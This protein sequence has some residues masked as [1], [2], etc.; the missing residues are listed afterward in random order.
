MNTLGSV[1]PDEG[2]LRIPFPGGMLKIAQDQHTNNQD[3]RIARFR[4]LLCPILGDLN[5]RNNHIVLSVEHPLIGDDDLVDVLG[6]Q[7]GP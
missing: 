3:A 7:Q 6:L 2:P 1:Y 5:S 4:E